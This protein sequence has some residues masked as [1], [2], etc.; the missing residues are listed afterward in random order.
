MNL[1]SLEYANLIAWIALAKHGITLGKTQLQKLLFIFYGLSLAEL[2]ERPFGDDTPKAFPFGPVF[3]RSY[4]RYFG[5]PAELTKEDK[6]SFMSRVDL[7]RLATKVVDEFCRY[8]AMSLSEWSHRDGSPWHTAVYQNNKPAWG[9]EISDNSI[10]D[11][12]KRQD[13][14]TGL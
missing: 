8:S 9:R 7:L 10:Q 14:K 3:P 6:D 2:G 13:W 4:K 12:F 11:F 5:K 1:T